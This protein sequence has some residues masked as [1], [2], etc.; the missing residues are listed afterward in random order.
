MTPE[1]IK[2]FDGKTVSLVYV[3]KRDGIKTFT[4]RLSMRGNLVYIYDT[5]TTPVFKARCMFKTEQVWFISIVEIN[6]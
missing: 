4:G 5:G 6:K 1:E 2:F 3:T